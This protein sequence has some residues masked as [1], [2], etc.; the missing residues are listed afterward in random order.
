MTTD[1]L[2]NR[3]SSTLSSIMGDICRVMAPSLH[4]TRVKYK[5]GTSTFGFYQT[6]NL[7]AYMKAL[8]FVKDI[9]D[10]EKISY[11]FLECGSGL[12]LN[13]RLASTIFPITWG[14]KEYVTHCFGIDLQKKLVDTA[15][16]LHI[17]RDFYATCKFLQGDLLKTNLYN[18]Y[19]IFYWWFPISNSYLYL[20]FVQ[21]VFEQSKKGSFFIIN[22]SSAPRFNDPNLYVT[23]AKGK[24]FKFPSG[25][26]DKIQL[27]T[28]FENFSVYRKI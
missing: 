9:V 22:E 2:Q 20:T 4:K 13:T 12:G 11:K 6:E 5:K 18:Q 10:K 3:L 25:L 14:N 21:R 7:D 15:N 26:L 8:W 19:N 1:V 28:R 17:E 23:D 27:L 16:K 24:K